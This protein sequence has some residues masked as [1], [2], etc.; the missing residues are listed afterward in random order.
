[1]ISFTKLSE[2][3]IL[4]KIFH[5]LMINNMFDFHEIHIRMEYIY[6]LNMYKVKNLNNYSMIFFSLC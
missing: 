6:M 5:K 2:N 3:H 4:D 1:M